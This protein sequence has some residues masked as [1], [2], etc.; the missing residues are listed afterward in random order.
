MKNGIEETDKSFMFR[1]EIGKTPVT[2]TKRVGWIWVQEEVAA[3]G[4]LRPF[5]RR[6]EQMTFTAEDARNLVK[7]IEE[8]LPRQDSE[9]GC[10]EK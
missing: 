2:I 8:L 7:A 3:P 5:R 9:K 1:R 10:P 4:F 6:I